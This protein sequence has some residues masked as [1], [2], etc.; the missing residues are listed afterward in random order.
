MMLNTVSANLAHR[1]CFSI[2]NRSVLPCEGAALEL[3][4]AALCYWELLSS[5]IL[6][7]RICIQKDY[8]PSNPAIVFER[9]EL[10][11]C[12]KM[13]EYKLPVCLARCWDMNV[14]L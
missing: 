3:L 14:V 6:Q 8:N 1:L 4:G 9:S 13:F 10:R 7:C 12:S 2:A 5:T 11:K